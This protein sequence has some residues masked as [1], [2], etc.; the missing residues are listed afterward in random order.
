MWTCFPQIDVPP[1]FRKNDFLDWILILI[2]MQFGWNVFSSRFIPFHE[3]QLSSHGFVMGDDF[4]KKFPASIGINRYHHPIILNSKVVSTPRYRT[5]QAIPQANYERN[6]SESLL[7][8]VWGCVPKVCWNN[9]WLIITPQSKYM[10]KH[11]RHFTAQNFSK[12]NILFGN[13]KRKMFLNQKDW[14]KITQLGEVC[15]CI[16]IVPTIC[17][18]KNFPPKKATSKKKKNLLGF[19]VWLAPPQSTSRNRRS[20]ETPKLRESLG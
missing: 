8:K 19:G 6:P 14:W 18:T 9:L 3:G 5:P 13:H 1:D 7:V 11:P 2:W 16:I 15:W 17:F 10:F 12:T 4:S 20:Q